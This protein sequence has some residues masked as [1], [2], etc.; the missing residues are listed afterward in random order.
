[1][2]TSASLCAFWD[3]YET[4]EKAPKLK[5]VSN[6]LRRLSKNGRRQCVRTVKGNVNFWDIDVDNLKLWA[7]DEHHVDVDLLSEA[8]KM[9]TPP[10]GSGIKVRKM[11]AFGK[12]FDDY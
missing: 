12:E 2:V 4:N 11:R 5:K 9:D 7:Q 10:A 3:M 1:M 6:V 8:L